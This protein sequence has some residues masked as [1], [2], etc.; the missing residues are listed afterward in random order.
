MDRRSI[1]RRVPSA[2]ERDPIYK[3]ATTREL[4]FVSDAY[5]FFVEILPHLK[6]LARSIDIPDETPFDEGTAI[7]PLPMMPSFPASILDDE[8]LDDLVGLLNEY[9]RLFLVEPR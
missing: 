5:A 1:T 6:A 8:K 9:D 7:L 4:R 3:L 2:S